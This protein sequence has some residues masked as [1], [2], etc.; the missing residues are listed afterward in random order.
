MRFKDVF[1]IIGPAMIGPSSS[2]TAGAARIGLAVHQLLGAVPDKA[3]IELYGSFA[4]T[5]AGHGTDYALVGG[6]LGWRTDDARLPKAMAAAEGAGMTVELL[7]RKKE[8]PRHPNTV[9]ITAAAAGVELVVVASSIGGGNIE[10]EE[11]DGFATHFGATY[12][13]LVL[14]H[15]DRRGIVAEFGAA[16]TRHAMNIANMQLKRNGRMGEALTVIEL[17]ES[18]SD[19]LTAELAAIPDVRSVRMLSLEGTRT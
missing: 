7:P 9:K 1:S 5:Y 18:W 11:I 8:V 2:H 15:L 17:D 19:E 16:L 6:L 12:P 13:T 4:E 3:R 10:I 14:C